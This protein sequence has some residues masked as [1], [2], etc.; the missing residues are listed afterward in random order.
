MLIK[1]L[2]GGRAGVA[3]RLLPFFFTL[4]IASLKLLIYLC[5]K[6]MIWKIGTILAL[7]LVM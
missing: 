4:P 1:G 2:H 6:Q 7:M 5:E 3:K